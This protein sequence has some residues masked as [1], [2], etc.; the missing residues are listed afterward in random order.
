MGCRTACGGAR[1]ETM[2]WRAVAIGGANVFLMVTAHTVATMT[3]S[4][5]PDVVD[6]WKAHVLVPAAGQARSSLHQAGS[7]ADR[8][9][10]PTAE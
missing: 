9:P 3:P 8:S 2:D 7:G 4:S 6:R 1:H 5:R 10:A